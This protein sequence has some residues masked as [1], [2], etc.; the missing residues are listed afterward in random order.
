MEK[1]IS[2]KRSRKYTTKQNNLE[3][4]KRFG[5]CCG[6]FF[7]VCLTEPRVTW[8]ER[9]SKKEVKPRADFPVAMTIGECLRMSVLLIDGC[10]KPSLPLGR[11]VST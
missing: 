2:H 8:E 3:L 9:A 10:R 5:D 7:I 1:D 4:K 11:T 6:E